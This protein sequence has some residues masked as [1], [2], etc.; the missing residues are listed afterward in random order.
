MVNSKDFGVRIQKLMDY[1]QLSASAFADSIETGRSSISHI[2]SGRNKP[3]LDF[4]LKIT[5]KYPEVD[6]Y[7]LLNGKGTFPKTNES[8]LD[9]STPKQEIP[10]P[11]QNVK[12][13]TPKNKQDLF[14]QPEEPATRNKTTGLPKTPI[15]VESQG[16]IPNKAIR[17]I[18]IFYE[19]GSF[20]LFKN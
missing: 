7:W 17:Q 4:V 1:Y 13:D 10:I 16:S 9:T 3:S 2:L 20:E 6:I 18:I 14:S 11:S 8:N 5:D 19:D 12:V 15:T